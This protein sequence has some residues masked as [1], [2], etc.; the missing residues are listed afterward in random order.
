MSSE[1]Q[2]DVV[3]DWQSSSSYPYYEVKKIHG[4]MSFD[5]AKALADALLYIEDQRPTRDYSDR[6]RIVKH[7]D[8]KS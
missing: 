4:S 2:Y 1:L 7:K 8:N 5:V 6:I 3:V